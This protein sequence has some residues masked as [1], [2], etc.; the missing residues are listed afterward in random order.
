MNIQFIQKVM[1][2]CKCWTEHVLLDKGAAF[3]NSSGFFYD[4]KDI[5]NGYF[6]YA[7][8]YQPLVA[9]NS[10]TSANIMSGVFLDSIYI[11]PGQSGLV[12]IN[13]EKGQAYFS[14]GIGNSLTRL[15][16]NYSVADYNVKLTSDPEESLLFETKFNLKNRVIQSLT[17]LNPSDLTYPVI[18]LKNFGGRTDPFAFGGTDKE[19][20][21]VRM[22]IISD[23]Q[24]SC[25]GATSIFKD[26]V[27]TFVPL[28]TG[29]SEMPFNSYGGYANG[30]YNYNSLTS[31][32]NH[33]TDS[34]WIENVDISS[35]PGSSY[36]ELR[37]V[38]PHAFVSLVDLELHAYRNPRI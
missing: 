17:G 32:R 31:G 18:Y 25:D 27:R 36:G 13:F 21:N 6:T 7:L 24:F 15:S 34:L 16:G 35:L 38:N 14:S 2:S 33:T 30:I 8:P 29:V 26:K 20:I 12:D 22:I 9:D 28:L 5:W 11:T 1:A 3:T 23:S 4:I 37:K 19:I 10:I